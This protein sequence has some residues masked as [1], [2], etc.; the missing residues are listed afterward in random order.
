MFFH[1]DESGNTGNNLFDL[2]QPRLSY[3][4]LSSRTNVDVLGVDLHRAMLKKLDVPELHAAE[5]GFG[6]LQEIAPLLMR[7]HHKMKF[8]FDYYFIEKK[9]Y[10]LVHLFEAI[11]DAGLNEAVPWIV[12]WT[13][14]RFI[15]IAELSNIIDEGLLKK[16][17]MLNT[18]KNIARSEADVVAFLKEVRVRVVESEIDATMKRRMF[19]AIDYGI[20]NPLKLDFGAAD[21]KLVSPN[22]VAFQFVTSAIARQLRKKNVSVANAITVDQQQQFN[23]AQLATQRNQFLIS[24]GLRKSSP[25][26]QAMILRHPLYAQLDRL[27]II[28]RGMPAAPAIIGK[29]NVSIG[30]QIVDIYLWLANRILAGAE[31]PDTL[32]G[33]ASRFLR[34]ANID[35][36]SM[37]GMISRWNRFEAQL[38]PMD[39][40]TEE[41]A[42]RVM[43][44]IER[45][46][47]VLEGLALR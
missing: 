29:S 22:A 17:W 5:L 9:D 24:R 10:A 46:E 30:I 41:Q 21:P 32:G 44:I 6:G 4:L 47:A 18:Q 35:G 28:G 13:P 11:F 31:L 16:S 14:M 1:I 27:D 33:L 43:K 37:D 7:L 45:H 42:E 38:P 26:D 15:Y 40:I 25:E 36:I 39:E 8:D 3:G 12:Y 2:Q 20:S 23:S 34:K 19:D